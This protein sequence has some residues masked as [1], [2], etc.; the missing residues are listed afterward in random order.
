MT[1]T[2]IPWA[3]IMAPVAGTSGDKAVMEAACTLAAPFGAELAA[4]TRRP[5]GTGGGS[6]KS[7]LFRRLTGMMP[8]R[9]GETLREVRYRRA[10]EI[11]L[12]MYDEVSLKETLEGTGF[13]DVRRET[14]TTSSIPD[15]ARY[16]LDV[17][18]DGTPWKGVSL[19]M[20]ARR[21]AD[22]Q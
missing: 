17:G 11:H 20:E 19:Y 16:G 18:P 14:P 21:G 1:A 7:R 10:G 9:L 12:W 3:R 22:G 15:F 5:Q 8:G 6:L 13:T 2:S 4:A